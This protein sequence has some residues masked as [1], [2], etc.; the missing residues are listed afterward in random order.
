VERS[1]LFVYKYTLQILHEKFV[2]DMA[3]N[4]NTEVASKI[5]SPRRLSK[6]HNHPH[7]THFLMNHY[8]FDDDEND[9]E[10]EYQI[11]EDLED[12][13]WL[14]RTLQIAAGASQVINI[15][16][17]AI[18]RARMAWPQHV[19]KLVREN[20]FH[21]MY[22][23]SLASFNRLVGKLR[24]DLEVNAR[25]SR[26]RTSKE[27]I[28][29]E[30]QMHCW[31]RC[32]AGGS[33]PSTQDQLQ[34]AAYRFQQCSTGGAIKNCV[35]ALDGYLAEIK[36]VSSRHHPNPRSFY[37]G[38]YN[39]PGLNVQAVCDSRCRF[40][41]FAV[42]AVGS[43]PDSNAY[44]RTSL[45]DLV[46]ALPLGVFIV[47]DCA[48]IVTEHLLTPFYGSQRFDKK[49]DN[50]NFF[51]SQLRIKIER[52]FGIMVTKW[53]ILRSP[54]EFCVHNAATLLMAIARIHNFVIDEGIDEERAARDIPPV[55]VQTN[56]NDTSVLGYVPSDVRAS[57]GGNSF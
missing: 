7:N 17:E 49:N 54:I 36:A 3:R 5:Q 57:S 10:E 26:M 9:S 46:E 25:F 12:D 35:G 23:M 39:C 40:I 18:C 29:P 43:S 33:F 47:A 15:R 20:A 48:Y 45:P 19:E 4:F 13:Q 52:A 11:V 56:G 32:A 28:Y 42:A 34:S 38:H 1:I 55:F 41:Y 37:S 8:M 50:Y 27:P 16:A 14:M 53:R 31:I 2:I 6:S 21:I 30:L 22:R 24:S 44:R 51:I